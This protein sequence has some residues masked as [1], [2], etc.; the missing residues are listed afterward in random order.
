MT[1]KLLIFLGVGVSG[2][3]LMPLSNADT[4]CLDCSVSKPKHNI[5]HYE[6]KTPSS[7]KHASATYSSLATD[8]DTHSST[9]SHPSALRG[10]YSSAISHSPSVSYASTVNHFPTVSAPH[11]TTSTAS[12]VTTTPRATTTSYRKAPKIAPCPSGTRLQSDGTCQTTPS[13][14]FIS[15]GNASKT[16]SAPS[17]TK[18]YS[19]PITKSTYSAPSKRIVSSAPVIHRTQHVSKSSSRSGGNVYYSGK[20][21]SQNKST[22]SVVSTP[23]ISARVTTWSA[24]RTTSS[25]T[26]TQTASLTNSVMSSLGPNEQMQLVDCPVNV[27]NPEGGT[28]L[29]CYRVV[30][31]TVTPVQTYY[32]VARP[33]IYVRYPVPVAVP[34]HLP[35]RVVNTRYGFGNQFAVS[36]YN[37][38]GFSACSGNRFVT[39]YGAAGF[40]GC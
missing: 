27:D 12:P 33:I 38:G 35:P 8:Y 11:V 7:K 30:R 31:E 20:I 17:T 28:I 21:L 36:R 4:D 40:G 23:A 37:M 24:P 34:Y 13:G 5:T 22:P 2:L 16:Y 15:S 18:T 10:R 39:R 3:A 9:Y 1:H 25:Y 14:S 32:Q 29:G 19:S 6:S 26:T